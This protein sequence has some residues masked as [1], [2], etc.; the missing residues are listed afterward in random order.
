MLLRNHILRNRDDDDHV[1]RLNIEN[2][3]N[4]LEVL[5]LLLATGVFLDFVESVL[6]IE[7]GSDWLNDLELGEEVLV[8]R[9]THLQVLGFEQ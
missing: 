6:G 3:M 2:Q 7:A 1:E 8:S 4:R 9:S 5:T